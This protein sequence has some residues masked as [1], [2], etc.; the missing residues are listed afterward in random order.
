MLLFLSSRP[1]PKIGICLEISIKG[2]T[3]LCVSGK[4][5]LWSNLFDIINLVPRFSSLNFVIVRPVVG[6]PCSLH[7]LEPRR[8]FRPSYSLNIYA[9][10]DHNHHGVGAIGQRKQFVWSL[11][12]VVVRSYTK[13]FCKIAKHNV[14]SWEI[15]I[16]LCVKRRTTV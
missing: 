1:L 9:N 5:V 2:R 10:D 12:R 6:L 11:S 3:W 14:T 4:V 7:I 8:C 13:A 16:S 15:F